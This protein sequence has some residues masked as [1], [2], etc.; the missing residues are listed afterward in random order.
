M[1]KPL[2][3][4]RNVTKLNIFIMGREIEIG[5]TGADDIYKDVIFQGI[6]ETNKSGVD[7]ILRVKTG[8]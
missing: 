3:F 2:P 7:D 1:V 4:V 8:I 5:K 6:D